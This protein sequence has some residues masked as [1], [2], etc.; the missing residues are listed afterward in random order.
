[1]TTAVNKK[2]LEILNVRQTTSFDVN[3]DG[4][5]KMMQTQTPKIQTR[6]KSLDDLR[7][8][9]FIIRGILNNGKTIAQMT[10]KTSKNFCM[11]AHSLD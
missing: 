5:I 11:H 1:M 2:K 7:S 10:P 8:I 9:T 3:P 4:S 6:L